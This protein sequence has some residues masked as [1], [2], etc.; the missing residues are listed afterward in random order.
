MVYVY[1]YIIYEMDIEG[2]EVEGYFFLYSEWYIN[3]YFKI[4]E[5]LFYGGK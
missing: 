1:N 4:R 5:S 2:L 3:G